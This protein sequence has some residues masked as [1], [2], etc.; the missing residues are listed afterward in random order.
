MPRTRTVP[1]A[2][3]A[4]TAALLFTAPAAPLAAPAPAP[5]PV[6]GAGAAP[7]AVPLPALRLVAETGPDGPGADPAPDTPPGGDPPADDPPDTQPGGPEPDPGPGN[8]GPTAAPAP[9]PSSSGGPRRVPGP[10]AAAPADPAG[11]PDPVARRA[12]VPAPSASASGAGVARAA[13]VRISGVVWDDRDHDGRRDA[14]EPGLPGVRVWAFNYAL[15][16][17]MPPAAQR[18][19]AVASLREYTRGRMPG[20]EQ[21]ELDSTTS[22]PDGRYDFGPLDPGPMVVA[23]VLSRYDRGSDT[24]QPATSLTTPH[25]GP[26]DRDSDYTAI[27]EGTFGLATLTA[28]AGERHRLDAG[29]LGAAAQALPVTGRRAADWIV[30]G[31][32]LCGLGVVLLR[33]AV[34]RRGR[35]GS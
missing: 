4:P 34:N 30:I 14:D 29:L 11:T 21:A 32:A 6:A 20:Y 35:P 27:A 16:D 9:A 22:G 23:V 26:G 24:L 33:M 2:L 19:A 28:V 18:G 8:G 15:A 7:A 31:A 12:G 3:L 17:P 13:K 1:A 25:A 5:P 10:A